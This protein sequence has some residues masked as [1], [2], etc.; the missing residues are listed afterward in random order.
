[1]PGKLAQQ[2][3]RFA[4]LSAEGGILQTLSGLYNGKGR[5]NIDTVLAGHAGDTVV[6]HRAGKEPVMI[7]QANVTMTLAI[8]P[9]VL[10]EAAE[11]PQFRHSG[12]VARF[13]YALPASNI[14]R[15][16]VRRSSVIDPGVKA[17]YEAGVLGLLKDRPN[18]AGE[19]KRIEF[20]EPAREAWFSFAEEVERQQ[21][22]GGRFEAIRD[23]TGKLPGQVA[24]I[25]AL[26]E[27]CNGGRVDEGVSLQ[28]T[29]RAIEIGRRLVEHAVCLFAMIGADERDAD[30]LAVLRWIKADPVERRVFDRTMLY[31]AHEARFGG[32]TDRATEALKRLGQWGVVRHERQKSGEKG[33]RPRDMYLVSPRVFPEK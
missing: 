4:V 3:E 21:G 11:N 30:A 14:G 15:R 26:I 23:W 19:P 29:E 20:T 28:S 32:N 25:A 9:G 13:L 17:R 27:L 24:R 5:S 10:C 2:G 6:V 1:L 22:D 33:G 16:D 18:F 8:Q 7:R 31:V 12:L